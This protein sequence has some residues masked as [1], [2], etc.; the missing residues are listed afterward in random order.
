MI[1]FLQTPGPIK[2][3]VL[4]SLLTLICV[5]MV[6]YLVPTGTTSTL[7]LGGPGQGVVATVAGEQVTTLEVQ[8]QARQALRQQFPRGGEQVAMLLP[9]FA[10][11]SA[12]NLISMKAM[13]AEAERMG[14]R[15]SDDELRD[16]L[17]HGRYSATFFP[18]GTF[19]GQQ[20]YENILQNADLSVR[21]FE[22]SM[23]EQLLLDKLRNLVSGGVS[24]TDAEVRTEFLK[25]NTRVKFDYAVLRKDDLLKQVRPTEAELKAFYERNKATYNNSIPETRKVRYAVLDTAKIQA[26][27]TVS[28]EELQTYYD[29]HRD[30]YRVPEQ[31]NVR[32]IL[33]KTPLPGSDGKVDPK[34]VEEARKKAEDV[35]KQLKAG[36]NFEDLAKKSSEDPSAKSGGSV[37]WIQRG[38]FPSPDVEKAAFSLSKGGASDVINAGYAFVILRVDDKQAAHVKTLD[39]GKDGIEPLLKQE[40]AARAAASQADAMIAQARSAGLEKAAATRGLTVVSTDFISRTD[41]LPGIGSSPQFT[42]AVFNQAEKAPP[43]L[44]QIATGYAVFEVLAIKPPA[45][46]TFDE[47]HS[48]VEN[49][50]K[51]ERVAALLSQK[52]QELADRAK[53]EH[54]L[55]KAATEAGAALKTSEFVLPEGQVPDIG[56]MA[57]GAAVAFSLKPGEISGPISNGNTGVVLSVLERQEPGP[58]DFDARKDQVRDALLQTRQAEMF[59]LFVSSLRTQMEKSG[60][61]KINQDEMKKLTRS[62]G[63]EQGE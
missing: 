38:R 3:I 25:R 36:A 37:G 27:T 20:Q 2:R 51:N 23:M 55:K 58:Q 35:L 31:V 24:V 17:Q 15:V 57:G 43:D 7:G 53:A 54:D 16:E 50:F 62:E 63:G 1:R 60:K 9:Y 18:G 8:R 59:N 32:Q 42:G 11:R 14:L 61:I 34:G 47:I 21:T 30:D 39:E 45:T 19:V 29:Q 22:Q 41:A 5:S 44:V 56:S 12:Q 33:I 26:E 49:E 40:K 4:G 28:R 46:P 48:R 10:A 13:V 6:W 52:T